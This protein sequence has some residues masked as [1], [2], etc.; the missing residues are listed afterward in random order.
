MEAIDDRL[1]KLIRKVGSVL[2]EG[3][4]T[5]GTGGEGDAVQTSVDHGSSVR[6]VRSTATQ[7]GLMHHVARYYTY[8]QIIGI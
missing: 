5:I 3:L 8:N 4:D 1:K 2:G 6:Q 7:Q